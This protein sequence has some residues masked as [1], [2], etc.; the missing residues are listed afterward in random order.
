MSYCGS[1]LSYGIFA[2]LLV[3]VVSGSHAGNI[4]AGTLADVLQIA[5]RWKIVWQTVHRLPVLVLET[6]RLYDRHV[7]LRAALLARTVRCQGSTAEE[8]IT[9]GLI[10]LG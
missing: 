4:T 7:G 8:A 1:F 5:A 9:G 6:W 2:I 3:F 10:R